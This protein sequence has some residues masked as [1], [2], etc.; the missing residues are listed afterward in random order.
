[1]VRELAIPPMPRYRVT[2]TGGATTTIEAAAV[3]LVDGALVFRDETGNVV[4]AYSPPAWVRVAR[5]LTPQEP[6]A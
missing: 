2:L 1:M 4:T 3:Y 5:V 6:T